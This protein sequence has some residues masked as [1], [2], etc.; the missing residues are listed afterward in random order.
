[1]KAIAVAA[2]FSCLFIVSSAQDINC[3]RAPSTAVENCLRRAAGAPGESQIR[4][5]CSECQNS[6]I[7]YFNEAGCPPGSADR[8]RRSKY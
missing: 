5:L 4:Q 7:E 1:M 6:L 8:I 2:I 3:E